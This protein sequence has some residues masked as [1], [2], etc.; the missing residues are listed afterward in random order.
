M[1]HPQA[2]SDLTINNRKIQHLFGNFSLPHY[3]FFSSSSP[4]PLHPHHP[5]DPHPI[6]LHLP[7]LHLTHH[8]HCLARHFHPP[9]GQGEGSHPE[10][11]CSHHHL[12]PVPPQFPCVKSLLLSPQ[13]PCQVWP[14][15]TRTLSRSSHR[16]SFLLPLLPL[17]ISSS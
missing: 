9:A 10:E 8:S 6:L 15:C 11:E 3:S 17:Q 14:G 2:F 13:S 5:T 12:H 16:S 1:N 4:H 7:L